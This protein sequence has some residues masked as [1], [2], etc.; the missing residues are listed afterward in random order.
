MARKLFFL[1]IIILAFVLT[2]FYLQ[3][4]STETVEQSSQ[5]PSIDIFSGTGYAALDPDKFDVSVVSSDLVAPTRIKI[6]PDGK[7][8][9]ITQITGD[10][11]AFTRTETGWSTEPHKVVTVET[12]VPGFPPE[13]AGLVGLIFSSN[14][15]QNGKVFLLYSFRDKDE[16]IQ[17]RI[18]ST[19]LQEKNNKLTGS[20]PELIFEANVAGST[21]HQITDGIA[22]EILDTPHLL[23][24]IGEGFMGKRA[25]DPNL[26]GGKVMIITE[27][28]KDPLGPRPYAQN[29]KIQALG[30]RNAY[31]IAS[32]PYDSNKVLIADTGPNRFD[33]II[34]TMLIDPVGKELK[35]LNFNW[36]G[37]EES[38]EKILPDPNNSAVSD[39]VLI[40]L[41]KTLTF[42]GLVI[43]DGKN[44]IPSSTEQTQS[45]LASVLGKTGSKDNEPGKQIWLGQLTNLATQ[46]K[47]SFE[48]I[49]ARNQEAQGKLGNPLALEVDKQ[50]G[51]F[52]FADILEGKLYQVKPK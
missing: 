7:F 6:T 43:H 16:K 31:N 3:S 34:Y 39:M 52:F 19:S 28:G 42:T 24:L 8:L 26:E 46:P 36:D 50:T 37:V 40:R 15:S 23:F 25:Q 4:R 49:I 12:S 22:L 29:P 18:S 21:S 38:L 1:I 17:N 5:V 51:D 32:N 47:L 2:Y 14:Y 44:S 20:T 9:L 41:E 11:L 10:V 27:D 45:V 35:P 13:E 48:P 30:I 33:R